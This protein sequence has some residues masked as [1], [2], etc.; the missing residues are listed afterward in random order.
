MNSKPKP[1]REKT[2]MDF[3]AKAIIIGFIIALAGILIGTSVHKSDV[4]EG[5]AGGALSLV[6]PA[7]AAA[8]GAA[9]ATGMTTTST[10]Q[11][12]SPAASTNTVTRAPAP[13]NYHPEEESLAVHL[14]DEHGLTVGISD[15]AFLQVRNTL[16]QHVR[17]RFGPKG[18][19]PELRK[20]MQQKLAW[21]DGKVL[22]FT[23]DGYRAFL[24][25]FHMKLDE[26]ES[27]GDKDRKEN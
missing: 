22:E 14:T 8:E 23:R 7:V 27:E 3:L 2:P 4:V 11:T 9:T 5:A 15:D 10:S 25:A 6:T 19:K 21:P 26:I 20:T 16:D 17:V 13:D 12:N 1:P 24:Q 18:P